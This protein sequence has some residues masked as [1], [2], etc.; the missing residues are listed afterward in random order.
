MDR[1]MPIVCPLCIEVARQMRGDGAFVLEDKMHLPA[2]LDCVPN[3]RGHFVQKVRLRDL[4]DRV[5]AQ[6]VE[7]VFEQPIECVLD[8]K[9][10]HLRW[11]KVDRSAPWRAEIFAKEGLGVWV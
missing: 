7:P 3:R 6:T 8:E 4:V 2:W 5:E 11:S 9:I 1:V 10:T